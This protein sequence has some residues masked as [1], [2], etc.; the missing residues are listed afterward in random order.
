MEFE[1]IYRGFVIKEDRVY[2]MFIG[3]DSN[4]YRVSLRNHA[5]RFTMKEA[6]NYIESGWM[7]EGQGSFVIEDAK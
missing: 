6:L 7:C 4:R 1:S 2:G 3:P 5:M